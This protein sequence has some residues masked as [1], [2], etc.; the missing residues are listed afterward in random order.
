MT[1]HS[2]FFFTDNF[3]QSGHLAAIKL[4]SL[5]ISYFDNK[6]TVLPEATGHT[7]FASLFILLLLVT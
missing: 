6:L 7:A 5:K 3:N 4:C 1:L 2:V